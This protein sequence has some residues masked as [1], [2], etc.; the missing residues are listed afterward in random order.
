[1]TILV[2]LSRRHVRE[3]VLEV[4]IR[5]ARAL[6]RELYIVHLV[7]GTEQTGG[8][9]QIRRELQARVIDENVVATIDVETV[10]STLA[11]TAPQFGEELLALAADREVSH[12]VVGHTAKPVIEDLT[13]GTTAFT[14]VDDATVPV[15]I[16]PGERSTD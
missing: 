2:A 9:S 7:E 12:I 1:M 16:V 4:G 6:G 3:H 13:Q 5:L 11:R 14:V 15:T 8:P 10:D